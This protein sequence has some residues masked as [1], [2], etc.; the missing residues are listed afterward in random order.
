MEKLYCTPCKTAEE[1]LFGLLAPDATERPPIC[2][3][4]NNEAIK[5]VK[6]AKEAEEAAKKSREIADLRQKQAQFQA[7]SSGKA[8]RAGDEAQ[9]ANNNA[10]K[11]EE[12]AKE[13]CRERD[14]QLKPSVKPLA[15]QLYVSAMNPKSLF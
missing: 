12:F 7:F 14:E 8:T 5:K 13:K 9:L 11:A 6:Q 2:D 4:Q 3:V 10:Q 15:R 1:L